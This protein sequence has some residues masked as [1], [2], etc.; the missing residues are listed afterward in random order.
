IPQLLYKQPGQ[1]LKAGEELFFSKY[2]ERI[3]FIT[4]VSGTIQEII[5][6]ER[7]RV[8]EIVITPD[9]EIEFKD[10]GKMDVQTA[11][12]ETLKT[13]IFESGCGAFIKQRPYNVVANPEDHPRDIYISAYATA[14]LAADPEYILE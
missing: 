4:P 13:R 9:A 10:F 14:P 8:M 1:H 6:G 7:R 3:R 5:R 12:A 2:N 11:D